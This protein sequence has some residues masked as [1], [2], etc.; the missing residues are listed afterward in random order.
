LLGILAVRDHRGSA[1]EIDFWLYTAHTGSMSH[2]PDS[3]PSGRMP[4][5][6]AVPKSR[7][8]ASAKKKE[9]EVVDT[10]GRRTWRGYVLWAV[11][12][13]LGVAA[14]AEFRAQMGYRKTLATCEAALDKEGKRT[15][16]DQL[17]ESLPSN[18]VYTN[19]IHS[20]TRSGVY[21]WTWQGLRRYKVHL[22]VSPKDGTVWDVKSEP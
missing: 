4:R 14:I 18:P 17:K 13:L 2:L 12:A 10:T 11:M 9:L 1:R 5:L 16:F 7:R 19:E 22:I 20:F 6:P 8:K 15:N 3:E 21:T